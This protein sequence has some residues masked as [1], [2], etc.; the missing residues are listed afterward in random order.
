MTTVIAPKW[1]RVNRRNRCPVCDKPDWCLISEDGKAVICA[2]IESDKPAGNR[3]AGWIHTLGN[4]TPLPLPKPRPEAKQTPKAAPDVL[5]KAYHALLAELTLS[6][7]HHDNLQRRGLTNTQINGLGYRT[8]PT[9]GRRKLVTRLQAMGIRLAG[10]PGFYLDAGKWQL[11]GPAGITIP[12]ID[13][14]GHKEY[15]N[16][17]IRGIVNE[18]PVSVLW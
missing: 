6:E 1:L 4:F 11:A 17:S 7:I 8:L 2:R 18:S 14:R 3:G 5:N 9:N 13:I 16:N 10:V 12:V 15:K